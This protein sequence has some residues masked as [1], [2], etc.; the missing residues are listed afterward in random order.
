VVFNRFIASNT[1]SAEALHQFALDADE[2]LIKAGD[3]LLVYDRKEPI[4]FG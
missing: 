1:K 3:I 4:N 2:A